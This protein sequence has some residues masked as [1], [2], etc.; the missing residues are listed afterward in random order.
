METVTGEGKLHQLYEPTYW[1]VC[2]QNGLL[3]HNARVGK[4]LVATISAVN[5]LPDLADALS[6]YA[7]KARSDP[8]ELFWER[9][10]K[11]IDPNLPTR[12]G[13]FFLVESQARAQEVSDQWFKGQGRH[14]LRTRIAKPSKVAIVDAKWLDAIAADWE[15]SAR[16]YWR[17]EMSPNPAREVLVDGVVYFPDWTKPPFGLFPG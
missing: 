4:G 12:D 13:A 1:H 14:I 8:K 5:R 11:E 15:G 9:V 17:G 10:R 7:I 6:P 2:Q 3:L 16:K